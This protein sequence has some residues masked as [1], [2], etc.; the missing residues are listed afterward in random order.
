MKFTSWYDKNHKILLVLPIAL[1]LFSFCYMVYFYNQNGDFLKRD[2]SL[3]G[4]TSITLATGVSASDLQNKL[5]KNISNMD[6]RALADNSGKQTHLIITTTAPKDRLISALESALSITITEKN[7]SI[8]YTS[9]NLGQ[10]F[11]QQLLTAIF[12]AFLLMG[13]VVFSTFG[14][15]SLMKV[16]ASILTLVALKLTFPTI[17][18]ISLLFYSL[19]IGVFFFGL[20]VAKSKNHRLALTGLFILSILLA[21][22]PYYFVIY[23][24]AVICLVL[25]TR[26]SAPSIA[27]LVSAFADILFTV[28]TVNLLGIKI[29]S[30]GIVAF[31]MLIGY[32]VGTDILL[33]SR[34]MRRRNESVNSASLGA[35]KTGITMTLTA[36]AAMVVSLLFVYRFETVLNQIFLIILIGLIYDIF[37]TWITNVLIIKWY[38]ESRT[39]SHSYAK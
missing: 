25:Y 5:S 12:F 20:Y 37:N 3:T 24:I 32:S 13:L 22:F 33:T 21:I 26:Y 7:S 34:V 38:A 27:V 35:F 28:V 19:L 18:Q 36:V 9:G 17:S 29:S 1:I 15:S 11:Y 10:E 8:E 2:V 30:G 6:I 31:L 4:G 23:P 39:K 14:E 16:Y